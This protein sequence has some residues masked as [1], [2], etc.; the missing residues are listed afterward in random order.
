M[1]QFTIQQE[2]TQSNVK[3]PRQALN[4]LKYGRDILQ[5]TSNHVSSSQDQWRKVFPCLGVWQIERWN[6][7]IGAA[8]TRGHERY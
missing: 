8:T 4:P 5:P 1:L 6:M 3:F 7:I 2:S